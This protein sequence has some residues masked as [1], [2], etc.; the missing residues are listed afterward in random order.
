MVKESMA[1]RAENDEIGIDIETAGVV[2]LK[3]E[4]DEV[5]SFHILFSCRRGDEGGV[6]ITYLTGIAGMFH[7]LCNNDPIPIGNRVFSYILRVLGYGSVQP[8][9][10]LFDL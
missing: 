4:R 5:M 9:D 1:V 2:I 8:G 7:S 10:I 3:R 6:G